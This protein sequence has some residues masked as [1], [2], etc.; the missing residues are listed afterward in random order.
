MMKLVAKKYTDQLFNMQSNLGSARVAAAEYHV[1]G[2]VFFDFEDDLQK[3]SADIENLPFGFGQ[4]TLPQTGFDA[5]RTGILAPGKKRY[6][7]TS[8]I[9]M[10][11]ILFSDGGAVEITALQ[12]TMADFSADFPD[13]PRAI[14]RVTTDQAS[15]GGNAPASIFQQIVVYQSLGLATADFPNAPGPYAIDCESNNLVE[16]DPD[17]QTLFANTVNIDQCA[18]DVTT[19]QP[20]TSTSTT[21]VTTATTVTQTTVT[22]TTLQALCDVADLETRFGAQ[23]FQCTPDGRTCNAIQ[24]TKKDPTNIMHTQNLNSYDDSG[25][26]ECQ[27]TVWTCGC[28][29]SMKC[30]KL[31]SFEGYDY[32]DSK[33]WGNGRH[34]WWTSVN[35]CKMVKDTIGGTTDFELASV[36]SKKENLFL[37]SLAS[38]YRDERRWLGAM[39]NRTADQNTIPL[40]FEFSDGT[41]TYNDLL[42]PDYVGCTKGADCLWQADFVEGNMDPNDIPCVYGRT[43][44]Y[45]PPAGTTCAVGKEDCAFMQGKDSSNKGSWN[46]ANCNF[47]I[48]YL[49]KRKK[50]EI[51]YGCSGN[52]ASTVA[53]PTVPTPAPTPVPTPAPTPSPT[54]EPTPS[55]TPPPTLAPPSTVTATTV[56]S[57]TSTTITT[58]IPACPDKRTDD[59]TCPIFAVLIQ[60]CTSDTSIGLL[61][62]FRCPVMCGCQEDQN[63][64]IRV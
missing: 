9:P 20:T 2:Q 19:T 18:R 59:A 26:C 61:L 46:D 30:D 33:P 17:F 39:R 29:D 31:A 4:P 35:E 42:L 10:V 64:G 54:L 62:K 41:G 7:R 52:D 45:E 48:H 14:V 6:L 53:P 28:G 1:S 57:T 44:S 23:N 37:G 27:G 11:I 13:I 40:V 24:C 12:N 8:D 32:Y 63:N 56:T 50:E 58:G 5:I 49:C 22:T 43:E 25:T 60:F 38:K 3:A 51:P 55:P 34:N 47:K 21:S 36:H 15:S 16:T